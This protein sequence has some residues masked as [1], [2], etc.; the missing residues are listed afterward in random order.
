M[1]ERTGAD[2]LAEIQAIFDGHFTARLKQEYTPAI[3]EEIAAHPLGPFGDQAARV[4]R[5]LANAPVAGKSVV[6][7]LGPD[8]PWAIGRIEIGA[9][10]NL[11]QSDETF[12]RYEDAMRQIF[13]ERTAALFASWTHPESDE[14]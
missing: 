1:S 7:S 9:A 14:A 2:R 3:V 4:V 13:L 12:A 11:V 6:L 8:G 5:A 10:G